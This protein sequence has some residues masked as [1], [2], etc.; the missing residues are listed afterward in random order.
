MARTGE[1]RTACLALAFAVALTRAAGRPGALA[2]DTP[3]ERPPADSSLRTFT[4]EKPV[5][6]PEPSRFADLAMSAYRLP[7]QN[8][9]IR[10]T[11]GLGYVQGADW[12]TEI[13]AG[14]GIAGTQVQL[15]TLITKG[16]EGS[17]FDQGTLRLRSGHTVAG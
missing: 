13:I 11:V 3:S 14:G 16:R 12:G 6:P 2:P 15:N 9:A 8:E 5:Q 17:V 4:I 1:L 7:S 10:A